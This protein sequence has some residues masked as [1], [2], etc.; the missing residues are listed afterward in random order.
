MEENNDT[1]PKAVVEV[2][3]FGALKIT[4]NFVLKDLQRNIEI[5]PV[6]I[7]LCRCG[8]SANKPHCDDSCKK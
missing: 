5:T 4:G 8:K 6:E 7:N 2:I 1:K 3:D